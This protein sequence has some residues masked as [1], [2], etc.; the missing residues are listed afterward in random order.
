MENEGQQQKQELGRDDVEL[1]V[2][3]CQTAQQPETCR[4]GEFE[5]S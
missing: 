3:P 2:L 1:L 4:K 5:Y